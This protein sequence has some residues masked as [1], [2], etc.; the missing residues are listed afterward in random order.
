M[1]APPNLEPSASDAAADVAVLALRPLANLLLSQGLGVNELYRMLKWAFVQEAAQRQ[2]AESGRLNV[3]RLAIITGLT[4]HDVA[5]QLRTPV[6]P[7]AMLDYDRQ[8]SNRVLLA[9]HRDAEFLQADGQ[10]RPLPYEGEPGFVGLTRKHSGDIPPRAMLA[11]LLAN[12]AVREVGDGTFLPS[13]RALPGKGASA[14]ALLEAGRRLHVVANA[15]TAAAAG[16]ANP[17]TFQELSLVEN[18][19]AGHAIELLAALNRRS[20]RFMELCQALMDEKSSP[21]APTAEDAA[22]P[23]GDR[24]S[25]RVGLFLS[26]IHEGAA[27]DGTP[28]RQRRRRKPPHEGTR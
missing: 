18:L 21:A 19:D 28:P 7:V 1:G 14:E 10:P 3:S 9:W 6:K 26:V 11:E 12:G 23:A 17:P 16:P 25:H 24:V 13:G 27:P 8:R 5:A 2:L 20:E 4:R 15:I 22:P